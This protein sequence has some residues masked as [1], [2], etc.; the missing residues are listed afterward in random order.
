MPPITTKSCDFIP[1][2]IT[3]STAA[4]T[5]TINEVM[6]KLR[7]FIFLYIVKFLIKTIVRAFLNPQS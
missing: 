4:A 3:I 1:A 2:F 6:S 7:P 5:N